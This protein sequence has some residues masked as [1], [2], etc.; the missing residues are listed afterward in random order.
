M[1]H[2]LPQLIYR[3]IVKIMYRFINFLYEFCAG[4]MALVKN[5][6][7]F[8]RA[9]VMGKGARCAEINLQADI[10]Q[11]QRDHLKKRFKLT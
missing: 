4:C 6:G 10:T 9:G 11:I 7:Y 3:G 5:C 2:P 8:S 1:G